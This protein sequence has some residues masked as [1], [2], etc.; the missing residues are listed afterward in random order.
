MPENAWCPTVARLLYLSALLLT[1]CRGIVII[2]YSRTRRSIRDM[3]K[4]NRAYLSPWRPFPTN[5]RVGVDLH[6]KT[7][8]FGQQKIKHQNYNEPRT[9]HLYGLSFESCRS[10]EW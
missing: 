3:A 7:F 9:V 2:R 6:H 8:S 10:T 5:D 4:I 1:Q